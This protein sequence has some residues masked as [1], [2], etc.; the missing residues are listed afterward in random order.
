MTFGR[1]GA[2]A[3]LVEDVSVTIRGRLDRVDERTGAASFGRFASTVGGY[4]CVFVGVVGIVFGFI[5]LVEQKPDTLAAFVMGAVAI[6]IGIFVGPRHM[7]RR[8]FRRRA[9]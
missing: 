9:R 7:F 1:A 2:K 6:G 8:L 4:W 3:D 5:D